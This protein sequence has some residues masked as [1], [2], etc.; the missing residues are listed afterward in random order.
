MLK[1]VNKAAIMETGLLNNPIPVVGIFKTTK[2]I[3][4]ALVTG[5]TMKKK[6]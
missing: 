3:V 5:Y 1:A 4:S 6:L 2:Q